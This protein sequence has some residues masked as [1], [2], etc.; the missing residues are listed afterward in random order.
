MMNIFV[1]DPLKELSEEVIQKM[2]QFDTFDE[3]AE[4]MLPITRFNAKH[5]TLLKAVFSFLDHG[6]YCMTTEMLFYAITGS[7]EQ[8]ATDVQ[9]KAIYDLMSDMKSDIVC[10]GISCKERHLLQKW[11]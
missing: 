1:E 8:K 11:L 3:F 7:N 2:P 6:V 5:R 9:R 10:V 4:R